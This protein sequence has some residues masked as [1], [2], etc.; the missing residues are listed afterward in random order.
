M[1]LGKTAVH[2]MLDR[3]TRE[4]RCKVIPNIQP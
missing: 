4:I 3:D 1:Y 2:G